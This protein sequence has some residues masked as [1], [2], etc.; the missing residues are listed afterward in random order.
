MPSQFELPA[1]ALHRCRILL[2]LTRK[3]VDSILEL[4]GTHALPE[5]SSLGQKRV[6][7]RLAPTSTARS[8]E[9]G[10]QISFGSFVVS[11]ARATRN[12]GEQRRR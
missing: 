3:T 2:V 4:K 5:R 10:L 12:G 7:L 8:I 9:H 1:K 11:I 6:E